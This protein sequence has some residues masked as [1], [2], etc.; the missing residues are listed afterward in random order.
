ML[1]SRDPSP[2]QDPI[3]G[4]T[5]LGT[6]P[7]T[8]TGKFELVP[9]TIARS[10]PP[11]SAA[12]FYTGPTSLVP[13]CAGDPQDRTLLSYWTCSRRTRAALDQYEQI[14]N[15]F[16]ATSDD[17]MT[18]GVMFV[19][20]YFVAVSVTARMIRRD[21]D[22]IHDAAMDAVEVVRSKFD[23][24]RGVPL[25]GYTMKQAYFSV[26]EHCREAKRRGE[27]I[28][29]CD[30]NTLP[31]PRKLKPAPLPEYFDT[32]VRSAWRDAFKI[33]TPDQQQVMGPHIDGG[34]PLVKIAADLG[35]SEESARARAFRARQRLTE[36]D[37]LQSLVAML[38]AQAD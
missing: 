5:G 22:M 32:A 34:V 20:T 8:V 16:A 25:K 10:L 7:F 29:P 1:P 21:R 37:A 28:A 24:R 9:A 12:G 4:P 17:R 23:K 30:V 14:L 19:C 11:A 15:G 18:D 2:D 13:Y 3:S 35:I 6:E 27:R 31:D 36:H 26:L 38:I 33:L